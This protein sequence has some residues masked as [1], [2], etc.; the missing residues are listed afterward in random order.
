MSVS[1]VRLIACSSDGIRIRE[2]GHIF[3]EQRKVVVGLRRGERRALMFA[4]FCRR[5]EGRFPSTRSIP[6]R[7]TLEL[8]NRRNRPE[9]S[10]SLQLGLLSPAHTGAASNLRYALYNP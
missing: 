5:V 6:L 3:F 8:S 1:I 7:L 9:K 4:H 10:P 2:Y